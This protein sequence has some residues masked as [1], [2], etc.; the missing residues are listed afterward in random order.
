MNSTGKIALGFMLGLSVSA[1]PHADDLVPVYKE[2]LMMGYKA[3][4][5][6]GSANAAQS[7]KTSTNDRRNVQR[8]ATLTCTKTTVRRELG[9]TYEM[10]R[11]MRNTYRRVFSSMFLKHGVGYCRP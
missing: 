11:D 10:R 9:V 3:G 1:L 7:Q 4:L 6:V 2:A 5:V 8:I